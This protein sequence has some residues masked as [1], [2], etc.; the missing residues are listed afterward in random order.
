MRKRCRRVMRDQ[1]APSLVAFY[2]APDVEI[3]ERMA[4]MALSSGTAECIHFDRLLDV[5]DMLLL[6]ATDRRDQ[7]TVEVAHLGRTALA[8][9]SARYRDVGKLGVT[10][11][12]KKALDLLVDVSIDW[13]ARQSG[14]L[15]CRANDALT[16]F[17]AHQRAAV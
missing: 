5:A 8:N 9:V 15:F 10:G 13:W 6:A 14:A 17:R 2:L 3:T 4:V 12:E 16:R 11:E 7:E 1:T